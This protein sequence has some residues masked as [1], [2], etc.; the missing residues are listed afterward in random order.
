MSMQTKIVSVLFLTLLCGTTSMAYNTKTDK[1]TSRSE[2]GKIRYYEKS[3]LI[4]GSVE[5][6]FAFMDDIRNTGKHMTENSASMMGGKLH[7][8]WLTTHMTGLGT[9]YRWTGKVVG[10]K[11]DFT[12]EVNQWIK[13]KEKTWGTI[14]EAKMIVISWFEMHL[15]LTP[16]ENNGTLVFLSIR[17]TKNK[18]SLWSFLFGKRY[19]KWCVKSMLEDTQK[20]FKEQKKSLLKK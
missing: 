14:G 11:M 6:V 3:I 15:E 4:E 19:A 8:E 9:K 20:H 17:Y 18:G 5:E 1:D 16:T 2:S 7:L 10:M 12:V 13:N